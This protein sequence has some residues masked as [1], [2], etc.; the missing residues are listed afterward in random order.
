[1]TQTKLDQT[2]PYEK[3][4]AWQNRII[5]L[6]QR[7]QKL[8]EE[9]KICK[10]E[11][12]KSI[13]RGEETGKA[14]IVGY[15]LKVEVSTEEK[16]TIEMDLL[17]EHEPDLL[18]EHGTYS[19]YLAT[20]YIAKNDIAKLIND[21][22]FEKEYKLGLGELDKALGGKKNSAQYVT[23]E[24]TPTETKTITRLPLAPIVEV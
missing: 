18:C 14:T 1:M 2:N 16:R 19:A 4:Y 12:S 7:K 3:A 17:K 20:R 13:A 15:S 5:E 6:E 9:I 11:Y 8:D 10:E 23:V 24:I 21:P 22:Y